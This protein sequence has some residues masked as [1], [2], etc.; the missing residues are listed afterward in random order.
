MGRTVIAKLR[1]AGF[2]LPQVQSEQGARAGGGAEQGP[3]PSRSPHRRPCVGQ[4][5][6]GAQELDALDATL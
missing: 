3:H 1:N 6:S 5:A 4:A 2:L